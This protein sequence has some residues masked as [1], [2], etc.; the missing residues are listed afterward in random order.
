[1]RERE[2]GPYGRRPIVLSY[3]VSGIYFQAFPIVSLSIWSDVA[4]NFQTYLLSPDRS[5]STLLSMAFEWM[6]EKLIWFCNNG[7]VGTSASKPWLDILLSEIT[8][9]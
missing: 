7:D 8:Q 4:A 9:A 2:V 3:W 6:D 1:M 5:G